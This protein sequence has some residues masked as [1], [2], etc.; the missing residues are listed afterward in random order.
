M[1]T[2]GMPTV[3]EIYNEA[4][5]VS[6]EPF[7]FRFEDL[8]LFLP[9]EYAKE[10]LKPE[11]TEIEW[12]KDVLSLDKEL[13]T[14]K[15]IDYLPFAFEKAEDERGLSA[16]RSIEYLKAWLFLFGDTESLEFINLSS[17]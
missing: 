2:L 11:V 6:E 8:V 15:I 17:N 14:N 9:Y 16:M 13:I 10:F 1:T 7:P 5:L 4:K 3:E 12:E